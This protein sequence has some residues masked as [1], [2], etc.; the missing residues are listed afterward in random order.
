MKVL[1]VDDD[2]NA[3]EPLKEELSDVEDITPEWTDFSETESRI[4]ALR[5]D[6]IILDLFVGRPQDGQAAGADTLAAIWRDHFCP[7]I[8]YSANPSIIDEDDLYGGHPFIKAIKKGSGSEQKALEAIREFQPVADRLKSVQEEAWKAFS[9]ALRDVS[10]YVP[11]NDDAVAVIDRAARRRL[12]AL[13]DDTAT[14]GRKLDAWEQYVFPPVSSDIQLGDVLKLKEGKQ[15]PHNYRVVLTP[16]CD[17]VRSHGREAKVSDVLVARCCPLT[18]VL[19]MIG[20]KDNLGKA[21][22]SIRF[23]EILSVGFGRSFILFPALGE[24]I[25]PMAANLKDLQLIPIKEIDAN[26]EGDAKY[27]IVASVDSPF[28]ETIAWA[29]VQTAARPGLPDRDIK[30]WKREIGESLPSG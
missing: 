9:I 7:V 28:R 27:Q 29:Y 4:K 20:P 12:A 8:V 23:R 24:H 11:S 30:S 25:P 14:A 17:L 22:K 18:K 26:K 15:E 10:R 6:V 3:M 2:R 13:L 19:N 1:L 21:L 5:P 16:S